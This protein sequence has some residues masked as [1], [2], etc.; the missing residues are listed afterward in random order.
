[1]ALLIKYYRIQIEILSRQGVIN[2]PNRALSIVSKLI[3]SRG[4][5]LKIVLDITS[6]ASSCEQVTRS[7]IN[8]LSHVTLHLAS[9]AA[10]A[11]SF[12]LA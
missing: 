11:I 3:S 6:A 7:A 4:P 8:I 9:A 10:L 5:L 1:M 12:L 2:L